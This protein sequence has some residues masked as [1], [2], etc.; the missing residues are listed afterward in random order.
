MPR[1]TSGGEA[2]RKKVIARLYTLGAFFALGF[3]VLVSKAFLF[4]LKDDL[5]LQNV[6][7]RQYRTAVRESTRRGK[8]LDSE[9]RELAINIEVPSV[10][11]DPRAI[12]KPAEMSGML[13]HLLDVDHNKLFNRLTSR[14]KFAWVKR[15]VAEEQAKQIE[16]MKIPG[17]YLEKENRRSYP[18]GTLMSA[19]LGAVGLDSEALGGVELSLNKELLQRSSDGSF[20]RDAR[21]HLYL[22]P[23]D[24]VSFKPTSEVFL[25]IDRTIQFIAERELAKTMEATKAKA[26]II[27]VVDPRNGDVLAMAN[28]PSFDPNEYGKYSLEKWKNRAISD[29]Y[30]PGSTFKVIVVSS[31]LESG[32]VTASEVFDCENGNLRIGDHVLHDS[33]PHDEL[34]VA[35]IVKVSSNIGAYKIEQTMGHERA[36][37]AIRNFGFGD[38][39]RIRLPGE[40]SGIL[41]PPSSWSE[42]Q[43]ATIA[44]GQGISATPLQMTMAFAAIANGGDLL[45]PHVVKKVR[46]EKGEVIYEAHREVRRH[47]VSQETA[48]TMTKMLQAVAEQ[49]GTGTLAASL[50]YPV[51]GKTGTAQKASPRGGYLKGQY[52]ASFIGFAPADEP[53]L[54]VYVGVDDPKGYFYGGQVA[55]P[56]FRDVVEKTLR[57]LKVPSRSR[58]MAK[59]PEDADAYRAGDILPVTPA[60][61][62]Q[63]LPRGNDEWE[64]PDFSGLTMRGVL[65]ATDGVPINFRFVGSGIAIGQKPIPG[66]VISDGDECVIE[67]RSA[68]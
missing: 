14:R 42:V 51:A 38:K 44:F 16:E 29:S 37:E 22:S 60:Q 55:A 4:H 11:A 20:R 8:I 45:K 24:E 28:A 48:R 17:V 66:E 58:L 27:I 59:K 30:E 19:V 32:S 65:K 21:G 18:N 54:V 36:Y 31:S 13:S 49:G 9:G 53:R 56:A 41:H 61:L 12:K 3:G 68:L 6:A 25:T 15:W 34:T 7:L 43:F 50:D 52:Y 10:W 39:T 67:F 63:L 62:P 64:I 5:R 46:N 57:Y 1:F 47:P 33:H 40:S 23:T 26:G 35:D 2:S